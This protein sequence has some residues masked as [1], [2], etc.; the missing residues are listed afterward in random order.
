MIRAKRH[1]APKPR[2]PVARSPLLA[3][4]AVHGKTTAAKRRRAKVGLVLGVLVTISSV[5]A[6]ALAL[7]DGARVRLWKV[8]LQRLARESETEA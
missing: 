2:N 8:E 1:V 4:G 5:G 7:R 6:G 3:K